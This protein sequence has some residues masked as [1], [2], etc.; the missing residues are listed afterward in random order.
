MQPH[1]FRFQLSQHLPN[2][3]HGMTPNSRVSNE[4]TMSV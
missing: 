2:A 4:S 1:G 3:V